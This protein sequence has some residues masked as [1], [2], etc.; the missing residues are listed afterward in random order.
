MMVI[1]QHVSY[2]KFNTDHLFPY[3]NY[4]GDTSLSHSRDDIP[5]QVRIPC[6]Y[7]V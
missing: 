5:D 4:N 3:Q 7:Q 2:L 6:T 1:T